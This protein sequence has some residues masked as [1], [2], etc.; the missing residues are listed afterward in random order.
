MK[1]PNLNTIQNIIQSWLKANPTVFQHRFDGF[2]LTLNELSSQKQITFDLRTITQHRLKEN[3]QTHEKYLNLLF[4]NG[5]E[6]V[7]FLAGVGF[8]PNFANTGPIP[9]APPV[10]C[11]E[12]YFRLLGDL[13]SIVKES[14]RKNDAILLFNILISILDGAK[15]VGLDVGREEEELDKYLSQFEK[16]FQS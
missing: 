14:D 5:I 13:T 16:G 8:S 15:A 9:D 2:T 12:D 4:D 1:T 11:M 10:S 3:P 6:V 7:L